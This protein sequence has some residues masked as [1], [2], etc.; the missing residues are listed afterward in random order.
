MKTSTKSA[1]ADACAGTIG[2][3]VAMLMFYPVDVIKISQ[4]AQINS[5]STSTD[6]NNNDKQHSSTNETIMSRFQKE[7]LRS[8]LKRIIQLYSHGLHYK[9]FHTTTSSFAYFFLY[10]WI[11]STHRTIS[12]S[13][14]MIPRNQK[15]H[16]EPKTSTRLLLAAIAAMMN[17]LFTLPLDVLSARSQSQAISSSKT[18]AQAQTQ[19]QTQTQTKIKDWKELWN[20]LRPSLLLC[21]NPTIHY[22]VFDM[23]KAN[24][25]RQR[26]QNKKSG[27]SVIRLSLAEAFFYGMFAKF[28]AT[29]ITYPLIRAKVLLMV[30][31]VA[32]DNDKNSNPSNE[33]NKDT[34]QQT[35]EPQSTIDS[36]S[37]TRI[38][39]TTYQQ[40]GVK[41]LYKGCHLQ[42]LHTLLKS[43][44]LMM[45]RERITASTR[46]LIL[47]RDTAME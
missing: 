27:N 14:A 7:R 41:G 28:V 1:L 44:L 45:C 42:L 4:Q 38:L 36:S 23:L 8:I 40:L 10:S 11:Q 39:V 15:F 6:N 33:Q 17:V 29:M 25:L 12:R 24:L 9:L 21:S 34:S 30:S 20:G 26:N 35:I 3:I 37:M 31:G 22:S 47:G 13:M 16:Y 19:T 43:A 46:Y 32:S 5:P 18:Q 2:S